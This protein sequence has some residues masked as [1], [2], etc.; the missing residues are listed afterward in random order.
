M[1][2]ATPIQKSTSLPPSGSSVELSGSISREIF[3]GETFA[4]A[5]LDFGDD[6][7]TIVGNLPSLHA[8]E[9]VSIAG[10]VVD[11]PKFG[12]QVRVERITYELPASRD[13][14]ERFL[15]SGLI[16]GIGPAVAAA[17][18]AKF[19]ENAL[20]V[21]DK[22]PEKYLK[23]SGIGKKTLSGIVDSWQEHKHSRDLITLLQQH[24]IS[25]NLA[26]R[27]IKVYG[28]KASEVIRRNPYQIAYDVSNVGFKRADSL[29]RSLGIGTVDPRRVHAGLYFALHEALSDGHVCLP[30]EILIASAA[31]LLTIET[32]LID[33]SLQLLSADVQENIVIETVDGLRLAYLKP[34]YYAERNVAASIHALLSV[35]SSRLS[36]I[37]ADGLQLDPSLSEE[38][39]R[40]VRT[41][42][43][44]PVSLITGGPGCGKS[45]L[46]K[47]LVNVLDGK[48]IGY[49][50]AAPTGRAA[51]RLTEST[52]QQA[53]TI[54][55]LL[56]L[57]KSDGFS[58]DVE[59]LS[60]AVLIIDEMS[61]VDVILMH[62]ILKACQPGMHLVMVG[63]A[64]QLPSVGPGNVLHDF[65]ASGLIPVTYLTRIFR[66][67]EGSAIVSAAYDVNRGQVP[68]LSN[69]STDFFFFN[70]PK[71]RISAEVLRLVSTT[72]PRRFGIDPANTQVLSPMQKGENGVRELNKALQNVLNPAQDPSSKAVY[73]PGDRV[74]QI[75]NNYDKGVFNGDMGYIVSIDPK[76]EDADKAV[77]IEYEGI[78]HVAYSL[79]EL[80]EQIVLSYAITIHKS[81][82]G[83][84]P[85]AVIILSN[86]HYV[87]LQ[88]N[89]LYTAITRAKRL[90]ILIGSRTA[91]QMAVN[92]NQVRRRHTALV[93]RLQ[94][95][96][97]EVEA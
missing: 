59:P 76:S 5:V 51:K 33:W 31:D 36:S 83:E 63:D 17:V 68:D 23:V 11:N 62:K 10:K 60:C 9:H 56:G 89:L 12:L 72:I 71:D 70:L 81:Q 37:D 27:I 74:M 44:T 30:V 19:G 16:K 22:D 52:G 25:I 32:T 96:S 66:Q 14:V 69:A 40:A 78:G 38:Q 53:Y 79:D 15:S 80:N 1:S 49:A 88:R 58:S 65:I 8:G 18:V 67:A 6:E 29:A 57:N 45:Y 73:R 13:G 87:M 7:I 64:D 20:D 82:G 91:I 55:R 26:A 85:C 43:S 3:R 35:D 21:L 54:H 24:D 61:M 47:A 46:V 48:G 39:A 34:F 75:K 77:I 97:K 41:A 42:I 50:L 86:E 2:L 95:V 4:V 94:A 90:C 28:A 92:N 84:Y 93:S